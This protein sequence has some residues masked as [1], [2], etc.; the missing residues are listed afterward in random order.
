MGCFLL[1][2][3]SRVKPLLGAWEPVVCFMEAF[4]SKNLRSSKKGFSICIL[5]SIEI[6]AADEKLCN[7]SFEI[8]P[9]FNPVAESNANSNV[10]W[11]V[12]FWVL[13]HCFACKLLW[14]P[15][16]SPF[17]FQHVSIVERKMHPTRKGHLWLPRNCP[18][19]M[20][21]LHQQGPKIGC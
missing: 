8:W 18:P 15:L 10:V 5:K 9:H 20:S 2:Q 14:Q 6:I 7:I 1:P 17:S 21:P 3:I 11:D 13:H 4:W 19:T 12:R 16:I